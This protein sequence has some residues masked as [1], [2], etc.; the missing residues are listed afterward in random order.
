MTHDEI[1]IFTKPI[2]KGTHKADPAIHCYVGN[3]KSLHLTPWKNLA[4]IVES[5]ID[6][7]REIINPAKLMKISS[8]IDM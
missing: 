5:E 6:V 2:T 7:I 8:R 1:V 3:H 4:L